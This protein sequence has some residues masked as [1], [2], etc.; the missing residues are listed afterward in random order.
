M[1][2]EH[3]LHS[4]GEALKFKLIVLLTLK[5]ALNLANDKCDVFENLCNI[6]MGVMYTVMLFYKVCNTNIPS[7]LM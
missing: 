2:L 3:K 1:Y 4:T 5:Y 7:T 6:Y